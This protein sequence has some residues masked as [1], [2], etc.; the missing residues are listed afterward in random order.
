MFKSIG[1]KHIIHSYE[2][3][4]VVVSTGLKKKKR[5][6][7]KKKKRKIK[8]KGKQHANLSVLFYYVPTAYSRFYDLGHAD[9]FLNR[10]R[11]WLLQ[12]SFGEGG[13]GGEK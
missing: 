13:G 9:E 3:I 10:E 6:Q 12:S 4:C 1:P 2:S 8:R 5:N 7:K 11:A